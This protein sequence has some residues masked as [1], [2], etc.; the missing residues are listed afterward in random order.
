[1]ALLVAS[2]TSLGPA[3]Q[4]HSQDP[5]SVLRAIR[6]GSGIC[7]AYRSYDLRPRHCGHPITVVCH[8]RESPYFD[9]VFVDCVP[10]V[11]SY[12]CA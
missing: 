9:D 3:L 2:C 10:I 1:M 5:P 7:F 12:R 8:H 6:F 4:E 11:P